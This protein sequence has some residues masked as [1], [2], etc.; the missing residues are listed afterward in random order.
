MNN[1]STWIQSLLAAAIGGAA[2]SLLST[3]A[4][5]DAFNTTHDGM[6]HIAKA[7]MIG[8]AVPVLTLL[9]QSPLPT[10]VAKETTTLTKETTISPAPESKP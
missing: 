2:S 6:I 4:M 5:P 7:A 3:L 8:A 10:T 1:L 9:K